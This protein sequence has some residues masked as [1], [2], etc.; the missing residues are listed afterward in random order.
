MI[1]YLIHQQTAPYVS[2]LGLEKQELA[3]ALAALGQKVDLLFSGDGVLQLLAQSANA[4]AKDFTKAYQGLDLF[5]I[6]AVYVH[7]QS[8]LDLQVSD[9]LFIPVKF[10]DDLPALISQYNVVV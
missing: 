6:N 7:K 8:A 4:Y 5:D 1:H 2:S 9:K 3:F 10:I